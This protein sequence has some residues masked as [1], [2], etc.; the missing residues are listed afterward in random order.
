[1]KISVANNS[2]FC[3][4]VKK[5]IEV[6]EE[7]ASKNNGKT[8]VHGQLVHNEKVVENL[9]KKGLVFSDQIEDGMV[10]K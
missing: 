10:Y 5:A 4:G 2:G 6:A 7:I 1:M 8:Y 9:G 3:F